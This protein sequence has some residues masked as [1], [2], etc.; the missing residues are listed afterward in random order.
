MNH[1]K[2]DSSVIIF[3]RLGS[4]YDQNQCGLTHLAEHVLVSFD[5][6][7][8]DESKK[9]YVVTAHTSYDSMAFIIKYCQTAVNENEIREVMN[10][11]LNGDSIE[12]DLFYACRKDVLEEIKRDNAG[13][14]AFVGRCRNEIL[15][16]HLPLGDI[17]TVASLTKEQLEQFL[18]SYYLPIEKEIV[19]IRFDI[20]QKTYNIEYFNKNKVSRSSGKRAM[21]EYINEDIMHVLFNVIYAEHNNSKE[22]IWIR[23]IM[24]QI[25]IEYFG[26]KRLREVKEVLLSKALFEKTLNYLRKSYEGMSFFDIDNINYQISKC[27]ASDSSFFSLSDIKDYLYGMDVTGMFHSYKQYITDSQIIIHDLG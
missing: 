1:N 5:K 13:M 25:Y 3:T 4:L 19:R 14:R 27:L 24:N 8:T 10:A 11:I 15:F 26:K 17:N 16:R 22:S 21:I 12:W 9:K 7:R 2:Y 20:I 18:V 6:K 23:N